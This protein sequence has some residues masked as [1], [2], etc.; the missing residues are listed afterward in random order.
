IPAISPGGFCA[1]CLLGL[2]LKSV[3]NRL[4]EPVGKAPA[5]GTSF[6]GA[7]V[8]FFADYE[9]LEEIAHGG[10]GI[11]FRARQISLKR[12]VAL[13]LIRAGALATKELVKRFQAEAELAAS[14]V[15]PH[16]V[17]IYEIGEHQGQH[18]FSMGL[19]E[20]PN[21]RTEIANRRSQVAN[22]QR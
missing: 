16:I 4:S 15:H 22:P 12:L 1:E 17:P 19:I 13:K 5:P 21:L 2:G 18:Y 7:G 9:L 3:A 14:L 20:G 6:A 10:M 8:Q 11:V